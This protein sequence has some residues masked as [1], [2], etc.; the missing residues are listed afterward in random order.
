MLEPKDPTCKD[1]CPYSR[2]QAIF[3]FFGRSGRRTPEKTKKNAN[4]RKDGDDELRLFLFSFSEFFRELPHPRKSSGRK[5]EP[6]GDPEPLPGADV[7]DARPE[8]E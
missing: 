3:F 1:R 8:Q 2:K 5:Q 7:E 6:L 4:E